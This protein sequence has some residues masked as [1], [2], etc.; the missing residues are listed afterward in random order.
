[1]NELNVILFRDLSVIIDSILWTSL[2]SGTATMIIDCQG[3]GCWHPWH[4]VAV[5]QIH[6]IESGNQL[7]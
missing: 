2:Q 1:M 7:F 5:V 3:V 6:C 4:S